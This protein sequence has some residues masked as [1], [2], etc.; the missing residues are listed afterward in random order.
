MFGDGAPSGTPAAWAS[1]GDASGMGALVVSAP[2]PARRLGLSLV[3]GALVLGQLAAPGV[4]LGARAGALAAGD[5]APAQPLAAAAAEDAKDQLERG[6]EFLKGEEDERD[7]AE[8]ARLVRAAAEQG[9]AEAQLELAS[10]YRHGVGVAADPAEAAKWLRQ[11]AEQGLPMAMARLGGMYFQG[12]G[13]AEDPI[14]AYAW[15]SLAE[16][17]GL[18]WAAIYV[19]DVKRR[20]GPEQLTQAEKLLAERE[21]RITVME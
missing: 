14:E 8:G 5:E 20:L 7:P 18:D 16:S 12:F 2:A 15:F 17:R 10:L 1:A 6:M 19:K 3:L 13:V 21:A 9:L 11:A 4:E